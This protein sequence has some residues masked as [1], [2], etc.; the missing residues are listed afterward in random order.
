MRNINDIV[1]FQ[2]LSLLMPNLEELSV[3]ENEL[4]LYYYKQ[5]NSK[6]C[7]L[8]PNL[9]SIDLSKVQYLNDVYPTDFGDCK[10]LKTVNMLYYGLTYLQEQLM[11]NFD[12]IVKQTGELRGSA[13]KKSALRRNT[14][15][16]D[17]VRSTHVK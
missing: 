11:E 4:L 12:K 2:T 6:L 3:S 14:D 15:T 7:N 9:R 13:H 1:T 10:S 5:P 8:F 16:I 17:P